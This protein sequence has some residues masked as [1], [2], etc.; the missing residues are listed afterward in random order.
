MSKLLRK[1][2]GFTLIELMIV[3]AIVGILAAIAIPAFVGYMRRSKTSEAAANLKA[4][5]TGAAAY[6][7][8]ENW[9]TRGVQLGAGLVNTSACTVAAAA[10]T[11]APA[12]SK[13]VL[14]WT[15]EAASFEAIGFQ[16]VDP[17]YYQY[18]IVGSTDSCAHIAGENLYS[19]DANGDLDGDGTQSL[20]EISSGSSTTNALMRSPGIYRQNELE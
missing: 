15:A 14:D 9:A 13:T 10:T 5:F 16:V 6:Y 4:M 8:N 1:K 20:F 7:G 17:V 12:A 2:S 11:N 18:S 3:V 19:F